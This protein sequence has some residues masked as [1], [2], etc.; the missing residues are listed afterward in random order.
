MRAFFCLLEYFGVFQGLF[1]GTPPG[2]S[3]LPQLTK[4]NQNLATDPI[5]CGSGLAREEAGANTLILSTG[6]PIHP[7]LKSRHTRLQELPALT[8][9]VLILQNLQR[10]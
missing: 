10:P 7:L 8:Q 3:P 4:L 5:P 1:V 6:N 9:Y 2:A